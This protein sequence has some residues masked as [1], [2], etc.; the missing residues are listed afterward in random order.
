MVV[1]ASLV[2]QRMMAISSQESERGIEGAAIRN[3]IDSAIIDIPHTSKQDSTPHAWEEHAQ[4][5]KKRL[6]YANGNRATNRG[7]K[8]SKIEIQKTR[9]IYIGERFS[10]IFLKFGN[11]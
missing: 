3:K 9:L 5:E 2:D 11:N 4:Y 10:I 6:R 1:N 7:S 8:L